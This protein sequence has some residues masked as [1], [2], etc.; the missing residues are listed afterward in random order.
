MGG[1]YRPGS[2]GAVGQIPLV[3]DR[4]VIER[5]GVATFDYERVECDGVDLLES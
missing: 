5:N 2:G 4:L 3:V 1:F